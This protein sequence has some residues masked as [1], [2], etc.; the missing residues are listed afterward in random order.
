MSVVRGGDPSGFPLFTVFEVVLFIVFG[1]L[2]RLMSIL[3]IVDRPARSVPY[4]FYPGT[5][6]DFC[7]RAYIHDI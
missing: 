5:L 6:A 1:V 3:L 7:L 2:R 4:Y